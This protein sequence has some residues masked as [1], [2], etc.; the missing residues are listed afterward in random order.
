MSLKLSFL[1]RTFNVAPSMYFVLDLRRRIIDCNESAA[2]LVGAKDGQELQ[3]QDFY[4]QFKKLLLPYKKSG[5]KPKPLFCVGN[6]C[7]CPL[8]NL[9]Q[10]PDCQARTLL[11]I[12][13]PDGVDENAQYY[14][15]IATRAHDDNDE[16]V[17]LVSLYDVT[18]TICEQHNLETLIDASTELHSLIDGPRNRGLTPDEL[19]MELEPHIHRHL[20]RRLGAV[21]FEMR[22]YNPQTQELPLFITTAQGENIPEYQTPIFAEPTQNGITGYAADS[23][24]TYICDDV[25][26]DPNYKVGGIRNASCSITSPIL[27]GK[28]KKLLG[29]VNIESKRPN[30]FGPREKKYLEFYLKELAQV[31]NRTTILGEERD[32]AF[33]ECARQLRDP[34][35]DKALADFHKKIEDCAAQRPLS[36]A[37]ELETRAYLRG[38]RD[39][40]R[41]STARVRSL[42]SEWHSAPASSTPTPQALENLAELKNRRVLLVDGNLDFLRSLAKEYEAYG[43]VVDVATSSRIALEALYMF[44]YDYVVCDL[45]PDGPYLTSEDYQATETSSFGLADIHRKAYAEKYPVGASERDLQIRDRVLKEIAAGKLDAYFLYATLQE[46]IPQDAS[47]EF[48]NFRASWRSKH[49]MPLPE[50]TPK[51]FFFVYPERDPTHVLV[52]FNDHFGSRNNSILKTNS[53]DKQLSCLLSAVRKER[54]A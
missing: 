41:S 53:A 37:K 31:L 51:P 39:A 22:L 35:V 44:D 26:N 19:R 36:E 8:H 28:E 13:S 11:E 34:F 5:R 14:E 32:N 29:V 3:G 38:I 24:E 9:D 23:K 7:F 48:L 54:G 33:A 43:L 47:Q 50:Q 46:I 4:L 25:R 21:A 49:P 42:A 15:M 17:T 52:D 45:F 12:P 6:F 10:N 30:A 16:A 27:Y 2:K 18:Q 1:L 20:K 40:L